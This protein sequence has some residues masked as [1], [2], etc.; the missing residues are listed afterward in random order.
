MVDGVDSG[1][2]QISFVVFGAP[3]DELSHSGVGVFLFCGAIVSEVSLIPASE[4]CTLHPSLDLGI[5]N[6]GNVSSL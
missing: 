6:S 4:A 2:P 1:G 5:L 3:V